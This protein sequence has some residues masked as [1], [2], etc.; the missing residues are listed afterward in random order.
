VYLIDGGGAF[1]LAALLMIKEIME[2]IRGMQGLNYTPS[3]Y[4]CF[5]IMAGTGT[6][7]WVLLV[8]RLMIACANGASV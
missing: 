1:G 5:D 8:L 2:R 3:P 4:E 6:G 7:G